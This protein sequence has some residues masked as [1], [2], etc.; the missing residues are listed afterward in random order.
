[1]RKKVILIGPRCGMSNNPTG[2]MKILFQG[3]GVGMC[4]LRILDECLKGN[5]LLSV[6]K[7]I[8]DCATCKS[9]TAG[10]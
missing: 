6:A 8:T 2:F 4:S 10:V 3:W 5:T 9:P 1:M 7:N